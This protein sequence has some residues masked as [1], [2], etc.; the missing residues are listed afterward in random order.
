MLFKLIFFLIFQFF[1]REIS[2]LTIIIYNH[3]SYNSFVGLNSFDGFFQ[4]ICLKKQKKNREIKLQIIEF[5]YNL[6]FT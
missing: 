5:S 2:K 6:D 4:V 3:H 1:F